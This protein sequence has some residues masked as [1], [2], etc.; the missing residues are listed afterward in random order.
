MSNMS[1]TWFSDTKYRSDGQEVREIHIRMGC[2][3][4]CELRIMHKV[5]TYCTTLCRTAT[6][7]AQKLHTRGK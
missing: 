6:Q 5:R 4:R 2:T 7:P 3:E 1:N